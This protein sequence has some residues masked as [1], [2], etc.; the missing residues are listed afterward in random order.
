MEYGCIG[1]HLGHSFSKEI[2]NALAEYEYSLKELKRA[3][4]PEFFKNKDFKA[5]NVTIP[6]KQDAIP[7][8]DW[9]SEEAKNININKLKDNPIL[10]QKLILKN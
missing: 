5:I 10:I 1:E 3:E 7:Y 4:L 8:L 6:Y 9:I 2:H